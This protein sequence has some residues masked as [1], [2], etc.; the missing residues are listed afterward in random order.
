MSLSALM[1]EEEV[2][3]LGAPGGRRGR[4]LQVLS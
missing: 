4:S 3:S 2:G 1:E